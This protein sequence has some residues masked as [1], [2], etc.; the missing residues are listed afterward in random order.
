MVHPLRVATTGVEIGFGLFDAL[1]ILGR[2][3][4]LRR[5]EIGLRKAA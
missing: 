2:D 1:A 3:Q 4:A 5:I